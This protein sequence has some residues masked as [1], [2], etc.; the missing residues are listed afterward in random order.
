MTKSNIFLGA[1]IFFILGIGVA[2]WFKE[3]FISHAI[4]W[5]GLAILCLSIVPLF[6]NKKIKIA[7]LLGLLFFLGIWRLVISW[8]PETEQLE[9]KGETLNY[10]GKIVE[11]VKRDGGKQK[12]VA[13]IKRKNNKKIPGKVLIFTQNYPRYSF[14]DKISL[15]CELEVPPNFP[16]FSYSRYLSLYNI[17][18]VCYY[19]EINKLE[20]EEDAWFITIKSGLITFRKKLKEIVNYSLEEPQSSLS[21]AVLLGYKKE[22][23]DSIREQF[24]SSG[25]SHIIAISG[26]HITIIIAIL[27]KILLSLNLNRKKAFYISAIGLFLYVFLIGAPASAF[28]A[29]LMGFLVLLAL[30][31]GRLNRIIN[32]LIFAAVILLILNPKMLGMDVGFQLSFL[33]VLGIVYI[34]PWLDSFFQKIFPNLEKSCFLKLILDIFNISL[35]VQ[36][37]IWPLLA[38]YFSQVSLLSSIGNILVLWTL[39]IVLSFM[40]PALFFG[41]LWPGLS[42]LFF[43]PVN[44]L[45]NYIVFIS[46]CLS[47]L[48]AVSGIKPEVSI[49]FLFIYYLVLS[50]F[51]FL[52]LF[53]KQLSK[54]LVSSRTFRTNRKE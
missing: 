43:S 49:G 6:E 9:S 28:R 52:P 10:K 22:L 51:I 12:I 34:Y 24:S 4:L 17:Y 16:D 40:F 53:K 14:G 21:N 32:S 33:A 1:C 37:F 42:F 13:K 44:L 36:V 41:F 50:F 39:P 54:T 29:S 30:Q 35:A 2:F 11:E 8:P 46:S 47:Q 15:K 3:V 25:L 20:K 48:N 7:A 27:F 5:F 38:Y 18:F 45:L 31:L 19:P 26:L 23:P